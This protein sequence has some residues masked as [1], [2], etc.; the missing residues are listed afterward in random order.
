MPGVKE[1]TDIL[2]D[3]EKKEVLAEDIGIVYGPPFG[4]EPL[5]PSWYYGPFLGPNGIG[6][7]EYKSFFFQHDK[8][9]EK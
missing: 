1:N 6:F 5:G 9:K 4:F 7:I 8:H 3:L 2:Y